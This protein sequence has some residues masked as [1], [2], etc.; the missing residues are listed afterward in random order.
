[1]RRLQQPGPAPTER[2]ES[3]AGHG[4]MLEFELQPGLSLNDALTR[5]LVA[6]GMRSATLVFHDAELA[7]LHYCIPGPPRDQS[8]VAWFSAP[9]SAASARIEIANTTFGWRDAA[10][11]VHCHAAWAEPDGRRGGHILP[12]ETVV[13]VGCTVRAWALAEVAI[14]AEPDPETN[15]ILFHPVPAANAAVG[16][17]LIVARIRPN[18]DISEAVATICRRHGLTRAAVRGSIGSLIGARF[19]QGDVVPDH[20]TEVLVHQGTFTVGS[21]AMLDVL[22]VDMQG[23]VHQGVLQPAA[24]PVCITF[25]LVLEP[26]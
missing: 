12:H 18:E 19:T 4:R 6:A 2:I 24:N 10:P 13:A 15:F 26:V 9:R 23:V 8:H 22:V 25:E 17:K 16:T 1:M 14:V 11:F 5:P 20:A 7:P 3:I 21:D